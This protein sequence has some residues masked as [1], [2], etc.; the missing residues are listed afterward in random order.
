MKFLFQVTVG[1]IFYYD[2]EL[3]NHRTFSG[4]TTRHTLRIV[5]KTNP[6]IIELIAGK[7]LNSCGAVSVYPG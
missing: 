5:A 6:S 2:D 7:C 4:K 3:S 1:F